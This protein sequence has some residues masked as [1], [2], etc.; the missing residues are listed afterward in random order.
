MS[1]HTRAGVRAAKTLLSLVEENSIE[2]LEAAEYILGSEKELTNILQLLR[3][4][5]EHEEEPL[6]TK[7]LREIVREEI[8]ELPLSIKEMVQT[9]NA[10][11]Q[12]EPIRAP[13]SLTIEDL[14]NQAFPRIEALD[15]PPGQLVNCLV[16]LLLLMARRAG[17]DHEARIAALLRD[18]AIQALTENRIFFPTLYSLA[19]LRLQW[20]KEALPY[21]H[22]ESR[23]SLVK[24]LLV[25]V[26]QLPDKAQ[27]I[28]VM[29]DLLREG[30]RSPADAEF[31]AMQRLRTKKA[32]GE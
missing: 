20:T 31:K 26:E 21:K 28:T 25:D 13:A 14:L 27:A 30:L 18:L 10:M 19:Q 22:H 5:K 15:L 23:R 3:K 9:V 8:L 24:R 12:G 6:T 7:R 11:V 4:Y 2:E 17:P 32:H 29:G 16:G 1:T